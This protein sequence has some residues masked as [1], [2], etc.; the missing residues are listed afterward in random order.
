M[1]SSELGTLEFWESRYIQESKT[2]EDD[3]C[4]SG[5]YWYAEATAGLVSWCSENF[6][7]PTVHTV[8]DVGCGNGLFLVEFKEACSQASLTGID[9][10]ASAVDFASRVV[11]DRGIDAHV[12]QCDM[13]NAESVSKMKELCG[14][15]GF[16]LV[17]DKGTLDAISLSADED[18]L[19]AYIVQLKRVLAANGF[20]VITSCNFIVD[21]L[22]DLLSG[23]F[24]ILHQRV[25]PT[26]RLFGADVSKVA[27]LIC[28]H[29]S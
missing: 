19:Q 3:H 8:L 21:E 26:I 23:D 1:E 5:E 17:H 13:T 12:L 18:H 7:V 16:D 6:D 10:S 20:L 28:K 22:R 15:E 2:W 11:K 9:Y 25:Y 4:D 27:T 29:L 14:C 24:E